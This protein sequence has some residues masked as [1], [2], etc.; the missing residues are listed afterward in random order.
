VVVV[1]S[2]THDPANKI[3]IPDPAWNDTPALARG[4][5]GPAAAS[6]KPFAAGQRRYTTYGLHVCSMFARMP[7]YG[8]AARSS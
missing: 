4:E 5:L 3:R 1:A 6:D 2:D 7:R 8:L